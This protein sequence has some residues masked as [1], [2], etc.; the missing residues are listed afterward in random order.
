M[1]LVQCPDC[2]KVVGENHKC[3]AIFQRESIKRVLDIAEAGD[4]DS[5]LVF[6]IKGDDIYCHFSE[7]FSLH[8]KV[9]ALERFKHELL[10][11]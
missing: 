7:T 8:E 10:S 1:S 4:Y 11:G 2:S 9:G 3:T 5:V 6:C